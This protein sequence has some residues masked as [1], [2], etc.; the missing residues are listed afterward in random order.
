[1]QV[2]IGCCRADLA[3]PRLNDA[4]SVAARALWTGTGVHP[5]QDEQQ[6][7]GSKESDIR[8]QVK[9]ESR[10]NVALAALLSVD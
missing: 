6:L 2:F 3:A 9:R 7:G 10:K 4:L 5:P 1:V 8:E